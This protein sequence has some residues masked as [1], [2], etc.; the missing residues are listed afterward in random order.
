MQLFNETAEQ[1]L[2][3][4]EDEFGCEEFDVPQE[5]IEEPSSWMLHPLV[6]RDP[7]IEDKVRTWPPP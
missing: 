4:A 3:Q 5:P 6:V 2:A 1:D 7:F